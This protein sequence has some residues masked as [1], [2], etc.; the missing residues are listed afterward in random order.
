MASDQADVT[1]IVR[2][3]YGEA[4]RRVLEVAAPAAESC[5]GP[6]NSCCGGAAFNGSVDPITSNLYVNGERELL[7]DAAVLALS[8]IHI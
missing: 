5:C 2:E 1:T 3:K 8:L 6:L 4:A 7:P